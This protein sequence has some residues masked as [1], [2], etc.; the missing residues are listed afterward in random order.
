MEYQP[1]FVQSG[2]YEAGAGGKRGFY[3]TWMATES[4]YRTVN[5]LDIGIVLILYD[6]TIADISVFYFYFVRLLVFAYVFLVMKRPGVLF[7]IC[8]HLILYVGLMKVP[9]Y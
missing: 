3:P 6:Y 2:V 5:S 8:I 1:L 4:P 7:M 9:F